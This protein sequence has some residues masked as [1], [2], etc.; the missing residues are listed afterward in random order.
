[1]LAASN[2]TLAAALATAT[3]PPAQAKPGDAAQLHIA[4]GLWVQSG[5]QLKD[6]FTQTLNSDFGARPQQVD[7]Q[8]K[9]DEARGE[10]N[11]WVAGQTA[12]KIKNLMPP[13][14]I[15]VQTKLVLANA[16]YLKAHWTNRFDPHATAPANFFVKPG[17]TV[18]PDFMSLEPTG[19]DYAHSASYNAVDLPY[20]NSTLSMLVVMPAPGTLTRFEKQL[21]PAAVARIERALTPTRV[22]LRM[23]KLH[24]TIHT[25]LVQ[26]LS[27]LGMP[28]AF[29]DG[30]DFSGITSKVPLKI[31]AVEHGADIRVD[32]QGTVAAAATGISIVATAVAPSRATNLTLDHPF[33]LFLRDERT[34]AILFAA[35]VADPTQA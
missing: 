2:A 35:R 21:T 4:N 24:L 9:P 10:I 20:L 13:S 18:Q 6:P 3:K 16:I 15:T 5:L 33:L 29:S 1:V 11:D 8:S 22:R 27:T 19:L 7:F 25:D 23:P 12:G 34:G 17:T 30:A 31:G 28:I 14:S 26:P 32:E